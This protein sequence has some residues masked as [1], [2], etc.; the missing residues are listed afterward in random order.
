MNGYVTTTS[1]YNK[2][3]VQIPVLPLKRKTSQQ[4][5]NRLLETLLNVTSVL[6]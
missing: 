5:E 1:G 2:N 3:A 6:Y 4:N